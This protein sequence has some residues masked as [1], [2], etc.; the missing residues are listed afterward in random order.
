MEKEIETDITIIIRL[1]E[2]LDA[3]EILSLQDQVQIQ[4]TM[5]AAS[6]FFFLTR[7]LGQQGEMHTESLKWI[8]KLGVVYNENP[9]PKM[10]CLK[11]Y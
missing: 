7:Q 5:H 1:D 4:A 6:V 11:N 10:S 9:H 2:N 8:Q 3:V